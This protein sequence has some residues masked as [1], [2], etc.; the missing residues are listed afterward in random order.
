MSGVNYDMHVKTHSG[1][2]LN[3][4][5]GPGLQYPRIGGLSEGTPVHCTQCEGGWY[6][7]NGGGWSSG[8]WLVLDRDYG[9]TSATSSGG[10]S[11]V[12]PVPDMEDWEK[13]LINSMYNTYDT[14]S[15]DI[16]SIRY[17]YGAPFQFTDI[18]DPRPDGSKLGRTYMETMLND[19]SMLILT[20]GKA[21][22][23][24]NFGKKA[25]DAIL[26]NLLGSSRNEEEATSLGNILQGK[27]VG[28]YYS[29]DGDYPEY[30][31]YVNNLAR[32]SSQLLGIGD[33]TLFD[34]SKKYSEFDWDLGNMSQSNSSKIFSFL[35]A[36]KTVAFFI[37][38][39]E[40]NFSDG[41]SNSLT[42]SLLANALNKGSDLTKEAI[43]LFGKAYDD[44]S[45]IDTS[46]NNF[47][48]AVRKVIS[49]LTS[50]NSLATQVTDRISDHATTLLN[51]GN[52]AFPQL[53]RDSNYNKSYDI[54]IKLISPYGDAES[55]YLYILVPLWHL[56]ALSYPRQ[57]GANGYS[58][59]FLVRAF[60]KGWFNCTMGIV[61]S[62]TIKRASQEGWSAYGYPTEV[63]V[64]LSIK[65]LYENLTI[66]RAGDYSTFN[67]TEYMD[68]IATWCGVNMNK[69]E[70]QRTWNM[71]EAFTKNK[72][73]DLFPNI[74]DQ[75]HQDLV[76][77]INK[78]LR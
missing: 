54:S 17:I 49:G 22:F 34:G 77:K 74:I 33:K 51:G 48:S 4:R 46:K 45:L 13:E 20:P 70:L 62:I 66:A 15:T 68:M 10:D 11:G 78:Y 5:S 59:P 28:R 19:M 56:V 31:K 25:S 69:P 30:M 50:N 7:H 32:I 44:Q 75:T 14:S 24:K 38:A 36:Q 12:P 43:F 67:N 76:N 65:D 63:D 2:G 6:L 72:F 64:N 29:F 21:S 60:C 53:W 71:Y 73:K 52:I 23:M 16:D 42:D 40:S 58:N 3:I 47:D 1:I 18:T 9:A 8:E 26:T 55:F 35:T 61:E 57:L 37:D 39:K 27:E 41:M